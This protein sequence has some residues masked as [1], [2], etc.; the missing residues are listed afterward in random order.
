ML[1]IDKLRLQNDLTTTEKRIADY[2]L[3]HLPTIPAINVADL[4]K[5]TYTSHSSVIRL[6]KKMGMKDF[7]IPAWQSLR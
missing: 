6:A 5:D 1:L 2:I 3:Q 4:A 7:G